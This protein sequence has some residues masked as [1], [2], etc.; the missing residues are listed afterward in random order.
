MRVGEVVSLDLNQLNLADHTVRVVG[1]GDKE[2]M[3]P[4]GQ[5]ARL[6][7]DAWL[8]VGRP[9]LVTE[10]SQQA[11]FLG[12]A[13][14]RWDQRDLRERLHKL[15]ALAGV[16]DISPHDLRHSLA[17][18]LLTGGADLRSVQE[19]LGHDS[20]ATTQLWGTT[21]QLLSIL[22]VRCVDWLTEGKGL[23]GC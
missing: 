14:K 13:S 11:L 19:I 2:R 18:H 15:A 6:A 7:L 21:F 3:V 4:F 20:L 12:N 16:P 8:N 17:T 22:T 1:K 10:A 23:V 9:R 5:P